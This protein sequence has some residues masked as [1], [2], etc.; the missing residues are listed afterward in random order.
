MHQHFQHRPYLIMSFNVSKLQCSAIAGVPLT[1]LDAGGIW[2]DPTKTFLEENHQPPWQGLSPEENHQ[3]RWQGPKKFS[4]EGNC[5]P[6]W[7]GPTNF[8]MEENHQPT[9][10]GPTKFSM[11][12]NHQSA[13]HGPT[14]YSMEENHR[15]PPPSPPPLSPLRARRRSVVSVLTGGSYTCR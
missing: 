4:M 15:R 6:P 7:Q 3:H 5:Q 8:S 2:Q 12:E 9:W 13:W 1:K 14:K 10:Q 11:E